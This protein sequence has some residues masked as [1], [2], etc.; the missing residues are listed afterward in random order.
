VSVP[1]VPLMRAVRP[2]SVTMA[3]TVSRQASFISISIAAMAPSSAP[4]NIASRPLITPSAAWVSQPSK[5]SAPMRG[6]S[7]RARNFA[8]VPADSAK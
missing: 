1:S 2:N 8:A 3:T 6:P 4:S 7:A 5:A